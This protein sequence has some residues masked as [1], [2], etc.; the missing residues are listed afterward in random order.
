M[1][2]GFGEEDDNVKELVEKLDDSCQKLLCIRDA[3]FI[4]IVGRHSNTDFSSFK[5]QVYPDSRWT[6]YEPI[7]TVENHSVCVWNF[8]P[9]K[10]S[11]P[12]SEDKSSTLKEVESYA[13]HLNNSIELDSHVLEKRKKKK[14]PKMKA[15]ELPSSNKK[16]STNA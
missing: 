16:L 8:F 4:E 11:S 3:N 10:A 7:R 6:I 13:D 2:K 12:C 15:T 14:D 1:T 9:Q 5:L